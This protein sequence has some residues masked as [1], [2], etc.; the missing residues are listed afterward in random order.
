M[1]LIRSE[2]FEVFEAAGFLCRRSQAIIS[3][4][5]HGVCCSAAW[6]VFIFYYFGAAP[7]CAAVV[8]N[9]RREAGLVPRASCNAA[10]FEDE[11]ISL[12]EKHPQRLFRESGSLP[13]YLM[14][15][16]PSLTLRTG[17]GAAE[18]DVITSF[19]QHIQRCKN[20][21]RLNSSPTAR[22]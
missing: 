17:R 21:R 7:Y 13:V 2:E 9:L 10:G 16:V 22:G 8:H 3:R 14:K 19:I 20:S 1:E 6:Q 12:L 5:T 18:A 15:T 4:C 11:A